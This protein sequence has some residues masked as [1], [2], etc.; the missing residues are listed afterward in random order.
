[1]A[2]AADACDTAGSSAMKKP[3]LLP[4]RLMPLRAD[5]ELDRAVFSMRIARLWLRQIARSAKSAA[6]R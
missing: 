2:V 4:L 1:V 3:P 6:M 5:T